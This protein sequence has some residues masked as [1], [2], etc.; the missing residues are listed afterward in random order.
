MVKAGE[1]L[2]TELTIDVSFGMAVVIDL[3][4]G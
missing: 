2:L 4:R 3:R 1:G